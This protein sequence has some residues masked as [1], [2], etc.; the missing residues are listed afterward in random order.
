MNIP[1]QFTEYMITDYQDL[2]YSAIIG[3]I[4]A[5]LI[6]IIGYLIRKPRMM[7]IQTSIHQEEKI[8]NTS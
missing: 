1:N 4:I 7:E 8:L 2:F 3:I 5:L 6:L